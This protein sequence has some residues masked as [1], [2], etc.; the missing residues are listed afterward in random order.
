MDEKE[1]KKQLETDEH[2]M[3]EALKQAQYAL[4]KEEV[5]IGAVIVC[6]NRIIGKGY[7]QVETLRD[8]T[9][10]A[11]MIAFTSASEFMNGKF[12]TECTLYVTIEPCIM[13]AGASYWTQIS[14][15]VFGARD[16]KRGFQ[17]IKQ[18]ILHPKTELTGGI[19]EEECGELVKGFF[20]SKRKL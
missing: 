4:S 10:H 11:E 1:E 12:L 13:C 2:F 14:R 3:R 8:V 16:E 18:K 17:K 15:I 7:N 6:N 5:P 20:K 9:A 19:L